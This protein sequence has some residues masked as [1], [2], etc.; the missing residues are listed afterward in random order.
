MVTAKEISFWIIGGICLFLGILIAGNINPSELGTD[1]LSVSI[2][3]II[4]FVLI[5]VAGMFWISVAA[6]V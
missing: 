4:A 1:L 2:A 5:L 6:E 3:Y